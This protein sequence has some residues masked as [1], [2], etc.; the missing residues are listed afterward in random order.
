MKVSSL[1]TQEVDLQRSEGISI[2]EPAVINVSKTISMHLDVYFQLVVEKV[3]EFY[4][5]V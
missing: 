2:T 1:L 4:S 3:F 5:K